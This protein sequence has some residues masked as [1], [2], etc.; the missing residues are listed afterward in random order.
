MLS[1]APPWQRPEATC[2]SCAAVVVTGKTNSIAI[3][4]C[5]SVGSGSSP[6][7]SSS[8][9]PHSW[10]FVGKL[11][12]KTFIDDQHFQHVV[13]SLGMKG[14]RGR[15]FIF[16]FCSHTSLFLLCF[17]TPFVLVP[18]FSFPFCSSKTLDTFY[19]SLAKIKLK[20]RTNITTDMIWTEYVTTFVTCKN[21]LC[22]FD[23]F[24][25]FLQTNNLHTG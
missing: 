23:R 24:V 8:A 4:Y 1:K 22:A 15:S 11:V 7:G 20:N 25:P 16:L 21:G 6:K 19:I 17:L 2:D 13:L 5:I 3:F 12:E 18:T 9:S 10:I 14:T